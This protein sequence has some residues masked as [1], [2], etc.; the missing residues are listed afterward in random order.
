LEGALPAEA[1]ANIKNAEF[2]ISRAGANAK[3]T[4]LIRR[5]LENADHRAVLPGMALRESILS[6]REMRLAFPAST[7][8]PFRDIEGLAATEKG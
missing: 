4:A 2:F 8:A 6:L 1:A 7:L 3:F 5:T